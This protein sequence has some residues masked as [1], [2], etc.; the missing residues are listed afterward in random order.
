V[1]ISYIGLMATING[2][3]VQIVM[4]SRILYGLSKQ[5]W[6]PSRLATVDPKR[7]TPRLATA[8]VVAAMCA[9]TLLLSLVSLAGITSFLVLMV[10]VLVNVSLITLKIKQPSEKA[11]VSVPIAVPAIAAL[12]CL[13]LVIFQA[14]QVS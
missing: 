7:Q 1:V 8:V 10:F 11:P 12:C 6:L 5:G 4:G 2:V 3:L 9:G 13:C 14:N